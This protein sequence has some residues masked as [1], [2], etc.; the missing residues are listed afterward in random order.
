MDCLIIGAAKA[1]TTSL[2]NILAGH[3]RVFASSEKEA[4]F[5]SRDDRFA[6]GFD[7]YGERYFK[8]A[9]A[10]MVRLDASPAYLTWSEKVAPRIRQ[11][12]GDGGVRLVAIL[13]DPVKRAYSHYW[14]R[15]RLGHESLPFADALAQE[16]HRLR[17][18]W[19]ELSQT[20][21]GKYGYLRA[22][23]YASRLRPFFEQ[24]D[25]SRLFFLLQDDLRPE[26]FPATVRQLLNFLGLD[27]V[28]LRPSTLNSP[29]EPRHAGL[30]RAYNRLKRTS[31]RTIY[32]TLVPSAVR[33]KIVPVLF[34]STDYP[35][36]DHHV[37]QE[38][39]IR[40][41]AEVTECQALIGRDLSHW[42]APQ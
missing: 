31:A 14:H 19:D 3:P 24:F 41:A 10:D 42:L 34:R 17:S 27:D 23:C 13:R 1:G 38:L 37:E 22:S 4:R 8:G 9:T 29:T 36:L 26:R 30:A 40:F 16:E 35:P 7:W 20:G 2:F 33:Q 25:R 18:N 12:Y 21:N 11:S 6:Q 5:F 32:T 28:P 39:R 15:V